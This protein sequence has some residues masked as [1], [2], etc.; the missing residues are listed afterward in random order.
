VELSDNREL[1][2]ATAGLV[3]QRFASLAMP[4]YPMWALPGGSVRWFTG[5]EVLLCDF[6][7]TWLWVRAR[8]TLALDAVRAALP[9]DWLM[10]P[11][12]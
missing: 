7:G 10:L 3:G 6:A 1:D 9:G 11:D 12:R 2:P 8:T 4:D 5:P